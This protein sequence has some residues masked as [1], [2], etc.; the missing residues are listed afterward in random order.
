MHLGNLE[1]LRTGDEHLIPSSACSESL[2]AGGAVVVRR[3]M[4]V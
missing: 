3:Q 2:A 1:I 4:A